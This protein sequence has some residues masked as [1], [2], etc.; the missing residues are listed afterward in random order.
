LDMEG[1][2]EHKRAQWRERE[3]GYRLKKEITS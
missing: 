2:H 1:N 3:L